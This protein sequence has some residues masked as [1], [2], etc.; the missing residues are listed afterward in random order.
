MAQAS[1]IKELSVPDM[2]RKYNGKPVLVTGSSDYIPPG[3]NPFW[4]RLMEIDF[5]VR[6]WSYM[7]KS[8]MGTMMK[9]IKQCKSETGFLIEGKNDDELPECIVACV[10]TDFMDP[11]NAPL[12]K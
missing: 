12:V 7:V 11:P 1:N 8:M 6:K 10:G 4:P 9:I 3:E 5:D 2:V